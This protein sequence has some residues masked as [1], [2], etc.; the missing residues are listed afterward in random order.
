MESFGD[1]LSVLRDYGPGDTVTL[2]VLR[3][4][5]EVETEVRLG[6]REE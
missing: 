4:G 6:E 1:L 3:D 5:E 2:T